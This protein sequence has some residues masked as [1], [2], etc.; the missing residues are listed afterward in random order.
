MCPDINIFYVLVF[1]AQDGDTPLHKASREG[2]LD[3]VKELLS[4][5]ANVDALNNVSMT[6]SLHWTC[7]LWR[8]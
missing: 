6:S 7:Q 3:V 4:K 5:G 2:H 8:H 1:G